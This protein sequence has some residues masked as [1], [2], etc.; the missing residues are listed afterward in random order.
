MI[1]TDVRMRSSAHIIHFF[2]PIEFGKCCLGMSLFNSS[3]VIKV[4][5]EEIDN[6]VRHI[7]S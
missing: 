1:M 2:V 6:G 7:Q 5:K 3:S 4:S